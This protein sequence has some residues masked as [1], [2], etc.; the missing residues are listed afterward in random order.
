MIDN[1]VTNAICCIDS[2]HIQTLREHLIKNNIKVNTV[3]LLEIKQKSSGI[4]RYANIVKLYLQD[5]I[6][7]L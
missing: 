5:F 4:S 2:A 1:N 3:K 6:E 7:D